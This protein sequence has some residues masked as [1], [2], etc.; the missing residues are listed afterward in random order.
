MNIAG[1][2]W[3]L[4]VIKTSKWFMIYMPII[5]LFIQSNG[6]S[7]REVMLVNAIYSIS[8]AFFEIPSGYFSDRLGRKNSIVLGTLFITAQFG[9]YSLSYD[10]WS[11][12]LGAVIGGLGAS[13]ISGTDS[14]LLYDSL[15][16]LDRK[17]DYLKWEGRTYAIGTFSEAVAAIIGGWLAYTYGLR[18]PVYAQVGI[19][20]IG[21]LTALTLVEPP[22]QKEHNR[23]NWEQMRYIL[24]HTFL[25]NKKLRFY[26]L[27]AAISGL[28]SL[29]LAWFA[30]PYF[31]YKNIEE[32]QIGYLWAALN[33]TVAF[34]ALNAHHSSKIVTSKQL[35]FLILSGFAIGYA[36]LGW[37]GGASL[38][39]GLTAMFIMYALRGLAT[40]S[41]LNLINQNAPS[42]M[43]ATV[44]SIRGFTVRVLYALFAPILGWVADVYSIQETFLL[45][46]VVIGLATI[47][48]IGFYS[49]ILQDKT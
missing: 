34:F 35:I 11:L 15:H 31:D 38:G 42:D 3:K 49:L 1:N 33:I 13:F 18:Y 47:V 48:A 16:I 32:N 20:F 21:V 27:L 39:I 29:L 7:L 10:F 6:L 28:S 14:A 17:G 4:Y 8:I 30:Q 12:G 19:S 25:E 9:A 22:I 46:G 26:I 44:L 2:I 43:R 40:P 36:V 24:R 45:M 23:G 5:V 37:Y 41:F